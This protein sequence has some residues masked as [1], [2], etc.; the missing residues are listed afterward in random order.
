MLTEAIENL[1]NRNLGASPGARQLCLELQAQ[2]LLI[3]ISGTPWRIGVESLGHSVRLSRDATGEFAAEVEGSLVN[4]AGLAGAQPEALLQRGA[5]RIRGDAELLQR[6]RDLALLLRPDLEEELSRLLGD[7]PAHQLARFGVGL[8]DFG[9]RFLDTTVRNG[10]EYLAHERGDLV[11]RGE[12][13]VF[14][15]GVD[16][17][18]EDAD[19]LGAR[20]AQLQARLET[21]A[22]GGPGAANGNGGGTDGG[23]GGG[24]SRP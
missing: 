12:A 3:V 11:P 8:L 14:F 7:A 21:P 4:L 1:L 23:T 24:E 13:E 10:A 18:R 20:L 6:Y 16:R 5:V 9:R 17:L 22:A 2:R 15:D 19:R